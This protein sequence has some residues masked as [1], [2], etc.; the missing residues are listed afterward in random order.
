MNKTL[1]EMRSATINDVSDISELSKQLGYPNS[2]SDI[3][4]RLNCIMNSDDHQVYVAHLPKGKTIAWIHLFASQ[5]IESGPI[6]EIG[7]F[8]VSELFRNKGIGKQLLDVAE[9]W[10]ISM[11]LGKLRVRSRNERED[12][13]TFYL[14][15]GFSITKNQSV[16]DKM[17]KKE[18]SKR[19]NAINK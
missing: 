9:K 16:Y 7:G 1:F 17:I 8:V 6:A 4:D 12:A 2:A 11:N 19:K 18:V 3:R 5:R 15:M 13:K 14:N 10:S